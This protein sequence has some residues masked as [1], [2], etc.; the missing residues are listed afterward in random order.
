L[1][2]SCKI[3]SILVRDLGFTVQLQ[4]LAVVW[5]A[6][7]LEMGRYFGPCD[8]GDAEIGCFIGLARRA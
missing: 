4:I 7:R 6:T 1:D 2:D 8:S 3:A 5:T